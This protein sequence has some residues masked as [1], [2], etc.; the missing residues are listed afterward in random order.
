MTVICCGVLFVANTGLM[1]WTGFA[2]G[3]GVAVAEK[4]VTF[5][6]TIVIL[7]DVDAVLDNVELFVASLEGPCDEVLL[8]SHWMWPW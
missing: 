4:R 8:P 2:A 5:G 7:V 1:E 3:A 6:G